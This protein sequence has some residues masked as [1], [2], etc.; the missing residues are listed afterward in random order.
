MQCTSSDGRK[1]QD[2]SKSQ[3]RR[4][5]PMQCNARRNKHETSNHGDSPTQP[6]VEGEWT[7][8]MNLVDAD[9]MSTRS[10]GFMVSAQSGP[11]SKS[12]FGECCRKSAWPRSLAQVSSFYRA[13]VSTPSNLVDAHVRWL[14]CC[15][16]RLETS[17]TSEKRISRRSDWL[18]CGPLKLAS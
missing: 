7:T 13:S 9:L 17:R 5:D 8:E 15:G 4:A 10:Q 3:K 12:D 2:V 1:W 14:Q 6:K 16:R 18:S 11:G